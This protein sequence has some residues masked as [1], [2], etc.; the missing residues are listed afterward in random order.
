MLA[1]CNYSQN[2]LRQSANEIEKLVLAYTFEALVDDPLVLLLRPGARQCSMAWS[3]WLS[4]V[5]TSLWL[6]AESGRRSGVPL[7]GL[8]GP[9]SSHTPSV[10]RSSTTGITLLSHNPKAGT[11]ISTRGTLTNI[12]YPN[13]GVACTPYIFSFFLSLYCYTHVCAFNSLPPPPC[14]P[15]VPSPSVLIPHY[16]NSYL[17]FLHSFSS[18]PPVPHPFQ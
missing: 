4:E 11:K 1:F 15:Y 3:L 7:K 8:V 18:F 13:H 17:L 6:G 5:L 16:P 14:N 9:S 2:I 10:I 12:S